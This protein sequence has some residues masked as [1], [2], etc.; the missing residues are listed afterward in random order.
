MSQTTSN[1]GYTA[2]KT[3]VG[4][5]SVLFAKHETH[6]RPGDELKVDQLVRV[7]RKSFAHV[8]WEGYVY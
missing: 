8:L 2:E 5:F 1:N 3:L 7:N 4:N 6:L